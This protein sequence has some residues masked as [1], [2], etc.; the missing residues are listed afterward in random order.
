M[1]YQLFVQS[2][3]AHDAAE[4]KFVASVVEMPTVSGEG[5]TEAEAI[6]QAKVALESKLATGKFVTIQI[7]S[8]DQLD[9]FTNEEIDPWLKHLGLFA[10]DPTFEDFLE[11]VAAYRQQVD[12]EAEA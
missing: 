5:A 4:Q 12:E 1:Q 2:L 9:E 11:E 6:A 3:S 10:D 8:A 7:R